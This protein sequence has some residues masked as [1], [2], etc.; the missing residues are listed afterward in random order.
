M[1]LPDQRPRGFQVQSRRKQPTRRDVVQSG[2]DPIA[3][4]G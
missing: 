4:V 3:I 2:G 1:M